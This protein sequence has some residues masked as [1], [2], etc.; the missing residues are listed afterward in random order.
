MISLIN[1]HLQQLNDLC[2]RH[3]IKSL[4][5][6]GSAATGIFN[7][8]SDIDF[9]YEIDR[10]KFIGWD[11]STNNYVDN[12]LSFEEGLEKLFGRQVDLIPDIPIQNRFLRNQI[13]RSKQIVYAGE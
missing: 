9:L 3:Y 4:Y 10:K 13:Q 6:F 5:V 12:L 8:E 7:D 2:R 11:A 1:Q